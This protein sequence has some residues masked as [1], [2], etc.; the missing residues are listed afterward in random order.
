MILKATPL[1][2]IFLF[3]CSF[4][5]SPPKSIGVDETFSNEHKEIIKNVVKEWC[6]TKVYCPEITNDNPEAWIIKDIDYKNRNTV[7]GSSAS[8]GWDIFVDSEN[9]PK[10][11]F[12]FW[13]IIAHEIG[14]YGILDHIPDGLMK[15]VFDFNFEKQ[16][17]CID[18]MTIAEWCKSQSCPSK[19]YPSCE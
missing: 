12:E 9:I 4:E 13:H 1:I 18:W 5:K 11:S 16:R 6:G 2:F 19:T 3:S 8:N 17:E 7:P 15:E 14:H 10:N